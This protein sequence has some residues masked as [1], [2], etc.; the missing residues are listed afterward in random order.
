M[1]LP[2]R[3][4]DVRVILDATSQVV[5]WFGVAAGVTVVA[6]L[7]LGDPD[8][9]SALAIAAALAV[10]LGTF[11][12]TRW[13]ATA[14]ATWGQAMAAAAASWLVCAVIGGVP[15]L[16]SG[17][18]G[19]WLDAT[20]EAMSGLTT[21][22]FSVGHDLDHLPA[23][24]HL[25]RTVLHGLGAFSI[26]VVVLTLQTRGD[27]EIATS[28]VPETHDDRTIPNV[29]QTARDVARIAGAWLTAG[30]VVL[31]VALVVAGLPPARAVGHA[32]LLSI[33]ALSTGGFAPSSQ[34]LGYYH[35]PAVELV[36]VVLMLAG[37]L[38]V[39]V[40]RALWTGDRRELRL[41]VE[42][43]TF[44][45]TFGSLLVVSLAGLGRSGAFTDLVPMLRQGGLT[46]VAA[47]TTTAFH[48]GASRRI[49]TDWGLMT[50]AA[51]VAAMT[52][53]GMAASAAGGVKLLR[54]GLLAKGVQREI[55]RVL[56]PSS[57]LVVQTYHQ[58]RRHTLRDSHVRAAATVLLLVLTSALAGA[59]LLLATSGTVDLTEALFE[60]TSA[61]TNTGLSVGVLGPSSTAGTKLVLLVQMWLGRLEFLAVFALLGYAVTVIR[62][63]IR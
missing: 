42:S 13:R 11:G 58:G 51:L 31:T 19:G 16:L 44:L 36:L 5:R 15:L 41:H 21:T 53:G 22:G 45:L 46:L 25:W 37:A 30:A 29:P 10:G 60:S 28:N 18:W 32:V 54:V 39:A 61:L 1:S 12:R 2:P 14:G 8:S 49:A 7:A 57:A 50:P 52:I 34:S 4:D 43:R 40:H 26:V 59:L 38:S 3:R 47:H 33:S 20:F 48:T 27:A 9:A 55:T 62:R 56:L 17:H 63:P 23:A 24:M 35:A 6:A